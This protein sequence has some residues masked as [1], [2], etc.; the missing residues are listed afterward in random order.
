M[1]LREALQKAQQYLSEHDIGEAGLDA[2]YLL[3][4]QVRREDQ[5]PIDRAWYFLHCEEEMRE[6]DEEAYQLLVRKRGAHIPLQHLTGVQE[7]MGL[8]FLVNDQVLIPRQDTEILVEEAMK[9]LA[10]G[11]DVLDLCTGSGCIILSLAKLVPGIRAV[12]TDLSEEALKVAEQNRARLGVTVKLEQG[13][14]WEPV[15]GRYDLIASNPPYIPTED[16][17]GLME[18]VR[19]HDPIM[20]LD[21]REDGLHFYRRLTEGAK[22][23]LKPGG[24]MILEIGCEQ[25]K[26]VS[27][28]LKKAG[29]RDVSIRKD[30]SGLDRV[31]MGRSEE[32]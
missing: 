4:H 6:G 9:V 28:L 17:P 10:P 8:E 15:E 27:D 3:E 11:M 2:W 26:A 31:V 18:E 13:D 1:K 20:A 22:S 21:G 24:W 7:F 25:G 19:C 16:I 23:Y 30:L 32:N 14:L 29:L 12:A 5:S